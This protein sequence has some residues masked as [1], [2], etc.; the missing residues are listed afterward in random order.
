MKERRLGGAWEG[1]KG[2]E[3]RGND[4]LSLQPQNIFQTLTLLTAS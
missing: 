1:L 3:G 4:A 2:E